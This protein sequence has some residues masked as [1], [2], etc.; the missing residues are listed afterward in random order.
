[1]MK[2]LTHKI[3][4]KSMVAL[5]ICLLVTTSMAWASED[6]VIVIDTDEMNEMV[7]EVL[8]ETMEGMDE[9]FQEL[10]ELQL[11]VRLGQDN[12]LSIETDDQMWEVNLDVIF[13]ELGE[14]LET[15]FDEIDTDDWSDH[16]SWVIDD[17]DF[18]VDHE[19]LAE[20]LDELK[21]ELKRLKNELKELKEI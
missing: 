2:N 4:A 6:R 3:N 14:A 15:A 20:E 18:E 12:Q 21:K 17:S 10:E 13:H 5:L 16:K 1:M 11:E 8:Q 19:E 9:V 7:A